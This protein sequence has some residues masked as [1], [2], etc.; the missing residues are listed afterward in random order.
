MEVTMEKET[1]NNHVEVGS[2]EAKNK[3]GRIRSGFVEAMNG[4]ILGEGLTD[5][6][7]LVVKLTEMFPDMG[8]K[9]IRTRVSSHLSTLRRKQLLQNDSRK[10][11]ETDG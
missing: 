1:M 10:K 2:S 5:V 4:L 3:V 6:S 9:K 11:Q 7:S 8:E